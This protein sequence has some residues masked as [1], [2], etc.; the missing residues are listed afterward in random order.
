MA[1]HQFGELAPILGLQ[2]RVLSPPPIF[3]ILFNF[4]V[5]DSLKSKETAPGL[6]YES[7]FCKARP[8]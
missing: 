3:F 1:R 8:D 7:L 6:S 4:A 5:V 2:V